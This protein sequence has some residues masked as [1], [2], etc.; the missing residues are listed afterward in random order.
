MGTL[1]QRKDPTHLIREAKSNERWPFKVL[2]RINDN[3]YMI[4]LPIEYNVHNFFNV[5]DLFTCVVGEPLDSRINSFQEGEG[6]N[7]I[8]PSR[9]FTRSREKELQDL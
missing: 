7:S 2:K 1:S 8:N 3:A 4:K 6:D 5:S 9:P